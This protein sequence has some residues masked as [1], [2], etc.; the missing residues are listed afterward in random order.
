[1]RRRKFITLVGAAAPGSQVESRSTGNVMPI[2]KAEAEATAPSHAAGSAD[3]VAEL[4]RHDRLTPSQKSIAEYI[5]EHSQEVAFST[6]DQMAERVDV[7]PSTIVRFAYRLGLNGFT[8][9]QERM[10]EL[11]RGQLSRTGD[12]ISESQA[13]HLKGTSF[14][15]SLSHDWQNLHHTIAGLDAVAFDRAVNALARAR[16][17]YVVAE[18]STFS[19]AQYFALVLDR[20]RSNISLLAS[21]DMFALPPLLEIKPEDCLLGFTFP[22]YA[23]ATYHA[24][25]WA[26]EHKAKVIAV[27]NSPISALGKIGDV[28]LLADSTGIGPQ[29]SLVAPIAVANALLNGFAAAKGTSA[30]KRCSRHTRM[31]DR[32]DA[33]LLKLGNPDR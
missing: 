9:L 27:T 33:F 16:R 15:A 5:I 29:N 24:A 20:L 28:V 31:M 21:D 23:K 13:G 32:W 2:R 11:V 26:K 19:I 30:L 7:N 25:V 12:P 10:Q 18:F 6:V 17:V 4:R 3:I 14:G 8:D 22:P 1:M